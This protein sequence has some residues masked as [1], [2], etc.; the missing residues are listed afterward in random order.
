[1]WYCFAAYKRKDA[2]IKEIIKMIGKQWEGQLLNFIRY[3]VVVQC[4]RMQFIVL[5]AVVIVWHTATTNCKYARD[6]A[7]HIWSTMSTATLNFMPLFVLFSLFMEIVY[8]KELIKQK[9][10]FFIYFFFLLCKLISFKF[11]WFFF[12]VN[13]F[14]CR[15]FC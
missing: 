8:Q 11:S 4:R 14:L 3:T 10:N 9:K 12:F 1:M 5:A 7:H 15:T 2:P 13:N 6:P